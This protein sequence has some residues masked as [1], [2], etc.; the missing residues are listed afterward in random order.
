MII[1]VATSMHRFLFSLLILN[2]ALYL[3]TSCCN[4]WSSVFFLRSFKDLVA[5]HA[6]YNMIALFS[7]GE[8]QSV[9]EDA[10]I[11]MQLCF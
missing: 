2:S 11:L 10:K 9:F 3:R 8:G 4:Y 1:L 6:K 5:S 7:N